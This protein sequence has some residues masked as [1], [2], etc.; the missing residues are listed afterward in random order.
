VCALAP[1]LA[2]LDIT[3]LY[4]MPDL[5]ID[6]TIGARAR[7]GLTVTGTR[8][9]QAT[10]MTA[11]ARVA[12]VGRP[13]AARVDLPEDSLSA[14]WPTARA[15]ATTGWHSSSACASIG[16]T[17]RRRCRQHSR[18]HRAVTGRR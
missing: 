5:P 7:P 1:A 16:Q 11:A 8:H 18:G 17:A 4:A 3:H 2:A 12:C 10:V 13:G 15:C 9:P 6:E 14:C